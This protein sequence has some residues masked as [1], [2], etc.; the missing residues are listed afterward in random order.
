MARV[1]FED[2]TM[3]VKLPDDEGDDMFV[4]PS[5]VVAVLPVETDDHCFIALVNDSDGYLISLSVAACV[6]LL[7]RGN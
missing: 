5:H 2:I 6:N 1:N 4:N 7:Q 3:F